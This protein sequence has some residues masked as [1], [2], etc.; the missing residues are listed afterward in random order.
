MI[1]VLQFAARP[2]QYERTRRSRGRR[3]AAIPRHHANDLAEFVPTGVEQFHAPE[4]RQTI[5]SGQSSSAVAASVDELALYEHLIQVDPPVRPR[6]LSA[7]QMEGDVE[8]GTEDAVDVGRLRAL[9]H[10]RRAGKILTI[11]RPASTCCAATACSSTGDDIHVQ[12]WPRQ[13]LC[14]LTC[15][16]SCISRERGWKWRVP[17]DSRLGFRQGHSEVGACG[18]WFNATRRSGFF[19]PP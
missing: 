1:S 18:G 9:K 14:R 15:L 4:N 13:W 7:I 10:R 6:Q 17:R 11:F 2:L 8:E 5:N 16:E 19:S 3:Y 12:S